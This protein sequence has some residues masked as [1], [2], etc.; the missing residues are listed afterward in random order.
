MQVRLLL[1]AKAAEP[2]QA[3]LS[4][5]QLP[6]VA[7]LQANWERWGSKE[8]CGQCSDLGLAVA[9]LQLLRADGQ[10]VHEGWDPAAG[11][12]P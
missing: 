11:W 4:S 9:L 10:L 5:M 6:L 2:Y 7:R 3:A 8:A 12:P 1:E